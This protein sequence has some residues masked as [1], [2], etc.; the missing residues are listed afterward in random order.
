MI[1][2]GRKHVFILSMIL[3][4]ALMAQ[5]QDPFFDKP[6]T[7]DPSSNFSHS[8]FNDDHSVIIALKIQDPTEVL[9]LARNGMDIWIDPK[10]RKNK[11]IGIHYPLGQTAGDFQGRQGG[12]DVNPS[13]TGAVFLRKQAAISVARK[14]EVEYVGF[15]P[16]INGKKDLS[17][18]SHI[19]IATAYPARDGFY[20]SV[21]I[22]F[23]A[24]QE[25]LDLTRPISVGIIIKGMPMGGGPGGDGPPGD[26][27]GSGPPPGGGGPGGPTSEDDFRKIFGDDAV[28]QKVT[29]NPTAK[30]Q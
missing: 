26:F 30:L 7:K 6:Y 5:A 13:D 18:T 15:R 11:K 12:I 21:R 25:P 23:T 20:Y 16:E 14:T 4:P 1:M 19:S 9:K 17:D 24:F 3:F 10:G 2:T 28:W 27:G 8:I 29:L 22:P